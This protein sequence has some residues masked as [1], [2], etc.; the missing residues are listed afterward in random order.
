[1]AITNVT[2]VEDDADIKELQAQWAIEEAENAAKADAIRNSAITKLKAIG[3]TD[4]EIEI[5]R[6]L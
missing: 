6:S 5:I 3:L 1:M 2:I 4:E